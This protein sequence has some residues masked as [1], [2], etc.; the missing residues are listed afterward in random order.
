M[1]FDKI[2][3]GGLIFDGSGSP[4]YHA[5]IAI[6]QH[7]IAKIS[8][9]LRESADEIIDADGLWICP[10]FIDIHTHYDAEIEIQPALSESVRHGVTSVI[11]G[12][13]SLSLNIGDP[14][15]NAD[16]FERVETMP[17][18][19]SVWKQQ[20]KQ[21]QTTAE[22]RQYLSGLNI[23]PNVAG[24]AG[25]SAIRA[26]VMGLE[27]SLTALA[28]DDEIQAM[29]VLANEA[30]DAGCIGISI[31]MVHWHRT[32]GL[33]AGSS[34]P[35]HHA[36]FK[37]YAALASVC[38]ARDAVFQ[39]TPNPKN[40][41]PSILAIVRLSYGIV[42]APLRCTVLSAMD[43]KINPQ[44]WRAFPLFTFICNQF[45]GCNIRFQTIAEP[46]TIYSD[47]PITPLFEEFATGV[48]LNNCQT[49]EQRKQ[50]WQ[51]PEF[52]Q[53]FTSEWHNLKNRTFDGDLSHMIIVRASRPEWIGLSITQIAH[54]VN[55]DP[56]TFFMDLLETE[57]TSLRWKHSGANQ[58]ETIRHRLL[59]HPYILPGFSDA[60]AH[61][62]NMAYFDSALS[63]IKQSV[64]SQF[65][66]VELA[67]KRVTSEPAL[68]FN[69]NTGR[70]KVGAQADLVLLDPK[71]MNC[72]IVSPTE[73]VDP[74]L[75][76]AMRM[77]KR[78]HRSPI[79]RV[80]INGETVVKQGE[81]LPVLGT[82]KLGHLL[83]STVP[84]IGMQ[85][86]YDRYRN[87]VNDECLDHPF[88]EYWEVFVLK[89]QNNANI[90]MHCI[91][92]VIM[93]ALFGLFVMSQSFWFIFAMPLS[94]M[95]GLIGHAYFERSSIDQRDT[96]FSWRALMCLHKLFYYVLTGQYA[97]ECE[98]VNLQL[99][100]FQAKQS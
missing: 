30:L 28:T 77:V 46:F 49:H 85:K 6:R 33:Y 84:V 8:T 92:F 11:M 27:R 55:K 9:H 81:P 76:D 17:E 13:C 60:G 47:G 99:Q 16:L 15:I 95:T 25:H 1:T 32:T 52:K 69:L 63:L 96:A 89:H 45:L 93:Y 7:K 41:W 98:R 35:S 23:G 72:P 97:K 2:F 14:A 3:R 57:D 73:H 64:Q 50:L 75:Q 4:P 19:I 29:V 39:V 43:L 91:A 31:D 48:L 56:L 87:R 74:D 26:H 86:I 59:K 62:R 71:L 65:M 36:G 88:K 34:L 82:I 100:Q 90:L 80:M 61:C 37:E 18:L 21:W 12:N 54:T 24:L 44:A 94:Q 83:A 67:V 22:Y 79:N 53:Q 5:D 68:W 42:R 20:A 58:R 38:R 70:I 78:D 51:S 66:P 40:L 10:G